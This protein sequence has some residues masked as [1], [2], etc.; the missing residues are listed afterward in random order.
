[1]LVKDVIRGMFLENTG[2]ALCDSGDA[3]GRHWE[4]NQAKDLDAEPEVRFDEYGYTI[5]SYKFL[6]SLG[7]EI[8]GVCRKFNEVNIGADDWDGK[9][10]GVSKAGQE[11]LDDLD[12]SEIGSFNTYNGDSALSQVLQGAF[13]QSVENFRLGA[14]TDE[15]LLIQ[16]HQGCDVR[17]GYTDARLFK[18][19]Y[20]LADGGLTEHVHGEVRRGN[21][22]FTIDNSYDGWNLTIASGEDEGLN[23][24]FKEGDIVSLNL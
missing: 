3:Y 2:K 7:L 17:A 20:G 13:L 24:E 22:V 23:Y 9:H 15:Y 8:D 10:Y 18:M 21:E 5:N 6:L 12:L 19:P 1:M 4:K 11:I 14:D 16:V